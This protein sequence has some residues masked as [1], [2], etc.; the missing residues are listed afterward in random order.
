MIKIKQIYF[1]ALNFALKKAKNQNI[2]SQQSARR[3]SIREYTR[4]DVAL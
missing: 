4:E 3:Q 1:D 2:G